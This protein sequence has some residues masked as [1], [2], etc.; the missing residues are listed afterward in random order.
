MDE[1]GRE[2]GRHDG[3]WRFTP[4]QR[5]G[6]GVAAASRSTSSAPTRRNA[7]VA[8]PLDALATTAVTVTGRLDAPADVVQAKLRSRSPLVPARVELTERGFTLSLDEPVHGVARGQT[9]VLYEGEAVV[10]AGTIRTVS[11][12]VR[13]ESARSRAAWV[14]ASA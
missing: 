4:G 12:G 5:K 7:V 13:S 14:T 6:L 9:A 11:N 8:G 1:D 3:F 10:G 2:L